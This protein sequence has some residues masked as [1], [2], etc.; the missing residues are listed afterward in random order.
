MSITEVANVISTLATPIHPQSIVFG[1]KCSYWLYSQRFL[2]IQ[3]HGYLAKDFWLL[4]QELDNLKIAMGAL[5]HFKLAKQ[6]PEGLDPNEWL[7]LH[8]KILFF[9]QLPKI[10]NFKDILK[11]FSLTLIIYIAVW[12]WLKN[13]LSKL[14]IAVSVITLRGCLNLNYFFYSNWLF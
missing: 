9:K 12:S 8:S 14:A 1:Y 6:V 2:A 13:I 4:S 11:T 10:E 3:P 5:L 7:A